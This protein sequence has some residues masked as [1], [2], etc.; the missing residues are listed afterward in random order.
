MLFMGE[1]LAW[2]LNTVLE[3]LT[4]PGIRDVHVLHGDGPAVGVLEDG[5]YFAQRPVDPFLPAEGAD[6]E[7]PV[8][9]PD[10]QTVGF[11]PQILV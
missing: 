2:H 9:V 10:R 3:P 11:Q 5:E 8:Q 7:L 6:C 4:L 1:R